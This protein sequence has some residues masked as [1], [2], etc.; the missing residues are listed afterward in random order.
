MIYFWRSLLNATLSPE[1]LV[2]EGG[3]LLRD[4]LIFTLTLALFVALAIKLV[5]VLLISAMLILPA[6]A[7]SAIS[8]SPERMVVFAA[9]IGV[10]SVIGGLALSWEADTQAGPSIIVVA[11][12]FFVALNIGGKK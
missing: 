9:L 8:R 1:L 7:A 12:F 6:A 2:A 4:R 5:G 10:G 3:S 11:S